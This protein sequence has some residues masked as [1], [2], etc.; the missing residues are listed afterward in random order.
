MFSLNIDQLQIESI[1]IPYFVLESKAFLTIFDKKNHYDL[2]FLRVLNGKGVPNGTDWY[3]M[4][5]MGNEWYQ[6]V[7]NGTLGIWNGTEGYRMVPRVTEW[8]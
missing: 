3:Q 4:V 8:Y 5:P 2:C 7:S 1:S 6:G